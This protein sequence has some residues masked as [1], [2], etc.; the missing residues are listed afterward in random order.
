M[1][2][3]AATSATAS[4]AGDAK[5]QTHY[6]ALGVSHTASADDVKKAYRALALRLHPDKAPQTAAQQA[7][8]T[9]AFKRVSTAYLVLCDAALRA[10]YD[11]S[12]LRM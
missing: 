5:S 3:A 1:A 4:G 8:A 7:D 11:R 10:D 9:A 6:A 2:A 12:L